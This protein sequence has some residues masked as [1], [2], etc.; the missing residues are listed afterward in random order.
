[1]HGTTKE[2]LPFRPSLYASPLL[3]SF[4]P[5]PRAF[6]GLFFFLPRPSRLRLAEVLRTELPLRGTRANIG[7][8]SSTAPKATKLQPKDLAFAHAQRQLIWC[9]DKSC[10]ISCSYS[11]HR[12][13]GFWL[14]SIKSDH[15]LPSELR[16]LFHSSEMNDPQIRCISQIRLECHVRFWMIPS[17]SD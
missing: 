11:T 12:C 7:C 16:S 3:L 9:L 5:P 14:L 15:V 2:L 8:A 1:M 4:W 6:Y 13:Q 17:I 10:L